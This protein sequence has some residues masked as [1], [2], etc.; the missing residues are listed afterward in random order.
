VAAL[1][2]QIT[3]S[4]EATL[5]YL[6]SLYRLGEVQPDLWLPSAPRDGQNACLYDSEWRELIAYNYRIGYQS[7]IR[8]RK[9]ERPGGARR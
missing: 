5:D 3:K 1:I 8:F 6:I 4:K 9:T 2:S 7:L